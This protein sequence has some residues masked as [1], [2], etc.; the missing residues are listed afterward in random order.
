MEGDETIIN[1]GKLKIFHELYSLYND[2]N[3]KI[4]KIKLKETQSSVQVNNFNNIITKF[5]KI[6]KNIEIIGFNLK[7]NDSEKFILQLNNLNYKNHGIRKNIL[8][9]NLFNKNF[10]I[11][12]KNEFRDIEFKIFETGVS[13]K[14]TL[15][16]INKKDGFEGHLKAK[17]LKSKFKTNFFYN[18]KKLL[19][20]DTFFRNKYL[21]FSSDGEVILKPFVKSKINFLIKEIDL[22][23][24]RKINLNKFLQQKEIIKRLNA[25]NSINFQPSKFSSNTTKNFYLMTNLAYGRLNFLNKFSSTNEDFSCEG[26]VNLIEVFP[27]LKFKCQIS[28]LNKKKFFKKFDINDKVNSEPFKIIFNGNINLFKNIINFDLIKIDDNYRVTKSDIKNYKLIFEKFVF[29]E[30]FLGIFSFVKVKKFIQEI[31]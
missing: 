5:L 8:K 29:D 26:K 9:G 7:V 6:K 31:S 13:G 16:N 12:I 10:K 1:I 25:E 2:Q 19:F 15:K 28:A 14:I 23:I 27:V 20:D 30:D 11:K 22:E 24:I 3:F 21:S 4:K 18:E 17:I